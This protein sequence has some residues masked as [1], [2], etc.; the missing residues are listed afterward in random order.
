[1]LRSLKPLCKMTLLR[2]IILAQPACPTWE[3]IDHDHCP[4]GFDLDPK[5]LEKRYVQNTDRPMNIHI[6]AQGRFNQRYALLCR[7]YLRTH[8]MAAHAYAEVKT[9]LAAYFPNNAE[10]YYDVKD[11]VFDII[12]A[13][14]FDWA[15][16]TEWQL[17][18]SDV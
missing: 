17:P 14:A 2:F 6:R 7:D 10:A 8:N 9:Q 13:A 15:E 4:K 1:M 3:D 16:V 12:M 11:P 18:E 5:E